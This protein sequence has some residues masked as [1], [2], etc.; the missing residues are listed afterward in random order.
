M[1]EH[2]KIWLMYLALFL[3]I[4]W[5]G[6]LGTYLPGWS[7]LSFTRFGAYFSIFSLVGVII[8]WLVG[9]KNRQY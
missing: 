3:A 5:V 9:I 1:K 2:D 7:D 6:A 8:G 4:S